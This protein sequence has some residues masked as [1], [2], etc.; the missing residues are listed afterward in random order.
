MKIWLIETGEPLPIEEDQSRLWRVGLLAE[1]LWCRGHEIVWWA[2]TYNHA[3]KEYRTF[4]LDRKKYKHSYSFRLL[5][6]SAYQSNVSVNRLVNH[7]Q[8]ADAFSRCARLE[9]LPDI[10]LCC[11]PTLELANAAI[12]FGKQRGIPVILD[13][14][15][16]W[17]Q[18]FVDYFPRLLR[19][20]ARLAFSPWFHM[21]EQSFSQATAIT[22]IT[23]AFLDKALIHA[24]RAKN[25]QT[26]ASFPH[27]Y[28]KQTLD[29]IVFHA[30]LE[31]WKAQGITDDP[32]QF[33][34]CFFG[35][36][37]KR[38]ELKTAIE[39]TK[40]LSE[41]GHS[42]KLVLCGKGELE[43]E[44]KLLAN[45]SESIIFPG[46]VGSA[47]I[48]TL[49]KLSQVGIVPYPST[50]DFAASIPNKVIEYFAG[51]L[52]VIA[53][54]QGVLSEL[55]D[56][57]QVGL[58]YPN[59][60]PEALAR[61]ILTYI[62]NPLLRIDHSQNASELF[63]KRFSADIVYASMAEHIEQVALSHKGERLPC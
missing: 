43:G 45:G 15:D 6:G 42:V 3:H 33:I 40:K 37:S 24:K 48:L 55:L 30:A 49:M 19:P 11:V 39:A 8:T 53:S 58:T 46:F 14:R 18:I 52:P 63:Q 20:L 10:I 44:C 35:Q 61:C 16:L 13:Y 41:S 2:S 1:T 50:D 28:A 47:E 26:D 29:P 25:Y 22:A 9:H 60:N 5:H 36:L 21:A 51:D 12:K 57:E 56:R 7:K 17:P 4:Q 62:N 31:F 23:D 34:I 38:I 32:S 59:N 27:G 54:I